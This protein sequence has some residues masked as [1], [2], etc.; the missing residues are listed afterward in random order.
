LC[1]ISG[2]ERAKKKIA[3]ATAEQEKTSKPKNSSVDTVAAE[4][5]L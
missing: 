3:T 1:P 2:T 4:I 5:G